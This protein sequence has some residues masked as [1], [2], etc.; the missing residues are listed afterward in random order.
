[1]DGNLD[2]IV[3]RKA[4]DIQYQYKVKFYFQQAQESPGIDFLPWTGTSGAYVA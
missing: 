3:R 1:M 4:T 2:P